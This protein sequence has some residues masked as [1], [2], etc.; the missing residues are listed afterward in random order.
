MHK[1][2]FDADNG[3]NEVANCNGSLGKVKTIPGVKNYLKVIC[4]SSK[5]LH[6]LYNPATVQT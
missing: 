4:G 5:C 1:K 2:I 6:D 3:H